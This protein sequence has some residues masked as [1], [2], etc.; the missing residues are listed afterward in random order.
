[1]LFNVTKNN[2]PFKLPKTTPKS[3]QTNN[4]MERYDMYNY[5]YN[6]SRL[7]YYY[8]AEVTQLNM[9]ETD[10]QHNLILLYSI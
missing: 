4:T 6:Y 10:L 9:I 5:S 1:M 2:T 8:T 7:F 3:S